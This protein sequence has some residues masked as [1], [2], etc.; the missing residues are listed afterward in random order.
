MIG[1]PDANAVAFGA[2]L[3]DSFRYAATGLF[4]LGALVNYGL[5]FG[6]PLTTDAAQA[7][8][9][10]SVTFGLR[11][12]HLI[13]DNSPGAPHSVGMLGHIFGALTGNDPDR[14]PT[15]TGFPASCR[16]L[17]GTESNCADDAFEWMRN[18]LNA[19]SL[20]II[21][22]SYTSPSG[23][24]TRH[25]AARPANATLQATNQIAGLTISIYV[26]P[27][28]PW[29]R[30]PNVF[31]IQFA[32]GLFHPGVQDHLGAGLALYFYAYGLS[33]GGGG[34]FTPAMMGSCS[35]NM[36]CPTWRPRL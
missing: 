5:H 19:N 7:W 18:Y 34:G 23:I 2:G 33:G 21:G 36:T 28:E 1:R 17:G 35:F 26:A 8:S 30:D 16:A 6:S 13:Q 12:I 10:D 11:V 3:A 9:G 4:G 27:G 32:H 14:D 24:T 31:N 25:G 20:S 15:L 22:A 29:V